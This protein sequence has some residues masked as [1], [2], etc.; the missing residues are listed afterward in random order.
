MIR[1][2][3]KIPRPS[4]I[5]I[6][7][8][9]LHGWARI[10]SK[11][12]GAWASQAALPNQALWQAGL[13]TRLFLNRSLAPR[14]ALHF[15]ALRAMMRMGKEKDT[16]LRLACQSGRCFGKASE[17][18]LASVFTKQLRHS[19]NES[20][21]GFL[22]HQ[23]GSSPSVLIRHLRIKKM[24]PRLPSLFF[25]LRAFV[26]SCEKSLIRVQRGEWIDH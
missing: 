12:G 6:W 9:E 24:P 2:T 10:K 11:Q 15:R 19:C 7:N 16:G 1:H 21:L 25:L 17:G 5:M 23:T 4:R 8:H 26:P 22:G 18:S 13:P 20:P 14:A 3:R